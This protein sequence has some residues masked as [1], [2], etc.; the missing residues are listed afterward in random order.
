MKIEVLKA[1]AWA[2]GS[3]KLA[4]RCGVSERTVLGW[5]ANGRM[6]MTPA[7]LIEE[8]CKSDPH[9]RTLGPK[10]RAER[11]ERHSPARA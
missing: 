11:L 4:I 2:G 8:L 9:Y 7:L 3:A 10:L 6:P 5:V 1:V